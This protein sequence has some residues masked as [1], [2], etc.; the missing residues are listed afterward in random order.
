MSI[1]LLRS[2]AQ[3]LSL[4][5]TEKQLEQLAAYARCVWEKKDFLNLTS[6]QTEE[7]IF[8][9]HLADGLVVA[10]KITKLCPHQTEQPL[11]IA[12]VGSGAG[13][14]GFTLAIALPSTHITCVESLE[15]R[16]SFMNWALLKT[17]LPNLRVQKAR[18]GQ[19]VHTQFDIVTER[20]MG[21]LVDILPICLNVVKPGG[22]FIAYQGEHPQ[23]Q[24]ASLPS[25]SVLLEAACYQLPC[26]DNRKRHVVVFSK[27][28]KY[29]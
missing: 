23:T 5:L 26:A 19:D 14:I 10:A 27:G 15:K 21:Q 22:F 9:R 6:V 3:T 17:G 28:E 7:E 12:D 20:A 11:A 25:G 2:F 16:C 8:T 4:S 1:D 24:N 18:L 29:V 13:Y